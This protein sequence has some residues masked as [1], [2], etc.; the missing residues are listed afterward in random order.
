MI[1]IK[2]SE[3]Q[4]NNFEDS[5]SDSECEEKVEEFPVER[6][7]FFDP[8]FELEDDQGKI[9]DKLRFE[10]MLRAR[11]PDVETIKQSIDQ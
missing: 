6:D 11:V 3:E 10:L 8:E 4:Q 2:Q 5:S 9:K 7:D 1:R